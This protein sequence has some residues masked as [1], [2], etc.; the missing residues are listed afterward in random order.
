MHALVVRALAV[1][2]LAAAGLLG[3]SDKPSTPPPPGDGGRARRVFTKPPG[4]VRA[5]PPH[6][7]RVEGVG[8][9]P[10][11]ARLKDVLGLLPRG[12]RVAL[13]EVDDVIQYSLVQAEDDKLV[14]GAERTG[15]VSFVTVLDRDIARTESGAG[16]GTTRVELEETLG[17]PTG[18]PNRAADPR[19]GRFGALPNVRFVLDGERVMAVAVTEEDRPPPRLTPA[20]DAPPPPPPPLVETS[21]RCNVDGL[22]AAE[23]QVIDTAGIGTPILVS[24]GCLDGSTAMAV[25]FEG[26]RVSVV[27]GD[28]GKTR[29]L[30]TETFAD[31]AFAAPIDVDG[32]GADE[33]ATVIARSSEDELVTRVE[34]HR[35]E[36]GKLQRVVGT[37]VYRVSGKSARW[38]GAK[39]SQIELLLELKAA[40]STVVVG[41]LYVQRDNRSVRI[42]A[43]LIEQ[44]LA[45]R[46]RGHTEP[47]SPSAPVDAGVPVD[48]ASRPRKPSRGDAG[49]GPRSRDKVAP[50]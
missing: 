4:T 20:P 41:G 44:R 15:G 2:V 50:K 33:L 22:R 28:A 6:A 29:R 49:R 14:I 13:I 42:V 7:I 1:A 5:V 31:L 19:I 26:E 17:A 36:A 27:A 40:E 47:A 43:P 24:Y 12:P 11:G 35:L 46:S 9:Y 34:V 48:G 37:D 25:A 21:K 8:P 18:R 23:A 39:L 30:R 16:V 38:A 45:V 3:C 10:L 32:D